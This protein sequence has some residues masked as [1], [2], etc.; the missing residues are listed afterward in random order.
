MNTENEHNPLNSLIIIHYATPQPL[1][2]TLEAFESVSLRGDNE[3][4]VVDNATLDEKRDQINPER[5]HFAQFILNQENVGFGKAANQGAEQARGQWLLFLNGDCV[6]SPA[7]IRAM[8]QQIDRL[9]QAGAVGFR[10]T[11][12]ENYPQL[13]FGR[14]P[15]FFSELK[16]KKL[17]RALDRDRADWAVREIQS[18]G[19][20][21]FETD[22]VSGSCLWVKKE[23]FKKIAGFDENF[24]LFFED[25][26]LC[27]RIRKLELGIYHCP[28][29]SIR[30]QHGASARQRPLVAERAYRQS[31]LYFTRKHKGALQAF[32]IRLYIRLR[33]GV[34]WLQAAWRGDQEQKQQ[35][36][37]ILRNL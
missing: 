6:L 25:I 37:E 15:T 21:P 23:V 33:L 20:E 35:A 7:D 4:I 32:G 27:R 13:T 10:Q 30:H 16:R 1:R 19:S 34:N 22:W 8:Q 36:V 26:D 5:F 14:F 12:Q 18:L 29:P 17:Q 28:E 31:Q 3:I 11:D 24:F 2:E 9:E